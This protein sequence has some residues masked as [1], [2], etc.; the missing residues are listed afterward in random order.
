MDVFGFDKLVKSFQLNDGL[1]TWKALLDCVWNYG[2]K[3]H[4]AKAEYEGVLYPGTLIRND[5]DMYTASR[6]RPKT[7]IKPRSKLQRNS[8][9]LLHQ[10]LRTAGFKNQRESMMPARKLS[11][12][13]EETDD[14]TNDNSTPQLAQ[15]Q[16]L[17]LADPNT[18]VGK[19]SLLKDQKCV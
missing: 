15:R 5:P 11:Y 4:I 17:V 3:R 13:T 7:A 8:K 19:S 6:P 12:I 9:P 10:V 18:H 16:P 2:N 1:Q 14:S